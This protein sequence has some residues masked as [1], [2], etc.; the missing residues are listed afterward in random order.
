MSLDDIASVEFTLANPGVTAAG[1]GVPLIASPNAT[2]VERTR[3][4]TDIDGVADDW[5]TATPEYRAASIMFSQTTGIERIMI[6]R[7]ANKPTQ[8]WTV[9]VAQTPTAA[10]VYKLRVACD[11]SGV[12]TSQEADYTAAAAAAWTINTAY[13]QGA[14]VVNDSAPLKFYVCITGGTSAG[15]GGPTG[16]GA[17]IADNTVTWMYAGTGVLATAS[18]DAIVY[19]LKLL[20][21][22]FAAPV[23]AT[24]NTLTGSAGSKSLQILANTAGAF[25]GV[26]ALDLD[27]L[28]IAQTHADPGIA[29]DLD[30]LKKASSAWYGLV[31]LYNSSALVLAAAGWAEANEKLYIMSTADSLAATQANGTGTDI[32]Q[33]LAALTYARTGPFFHPANDE[34]ADAAEIARWFPIPPGGDDWVLKSLAGVTV[35]TYTETQQTNLIAKHANYYADLGG[36]NAVQGEGKVSANEYIDV[37]RGRDWYKARLQERIVN[38]RLSAEKIPFTPGGIAVFETLLK[39]QNDEGVDAGFIAPNT[40]DTPITVVMPKLSAISTADKQARW[41]RT[42]RVTFTLAGS[43][44]KISVTVQATP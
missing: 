35:R 10:A 43:V 44:H 21:D 41:L 30:A 22:A 34:F 42:A 4:Y 37:I 18:N 39:A 25:F 2:W 14:V 15:A 7:C 9:G 6:G 28:A 29:A 38:A 12:W 17:S 32:L 26:E 16:T 23:L 3:T 19:N 8:K 33:S 20:L 36:A 13:A 31:T 11:N 24:T 40:P 5:G 1:F 27:F